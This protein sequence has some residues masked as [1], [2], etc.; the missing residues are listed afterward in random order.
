MVLVF[1]VI[2]VVRGGV[3]AA[4]LI[5]VVSTVV[6]V[7]AHVVR[8]DAVAVCT[9]VLV[10][11]AVCGWQRNQQHVRPLIPLATASP[12]HLVSQ[13]FQKFLFL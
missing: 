8:G 6:P 11:R 4:L 2:I 3:T 5:T 7:V 1:V 13:K 10:Q 9:L 12:S